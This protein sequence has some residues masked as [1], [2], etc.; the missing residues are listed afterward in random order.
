MDCEPCLAGTYGE[1]VHDINEFEKVPDWL[2]LR[3]CTAVT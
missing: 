2:R 1:Q 3:K